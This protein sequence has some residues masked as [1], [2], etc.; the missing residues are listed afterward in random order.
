MEPRIFVSSTFYDLKHVR[1]RLGHFIEGYGFKPVLFENGDVGYRPGEELDQSCFFEMKNCDMAILIVGGR[2]GSPVS[3]EKQAEYETRDN[4][5][6]YTSVTCRE[7]KTAIQENIPVYVFVDTSVHEQ[8]NIYKHNMVAIEEKK[9]EIT[10]P[11]VDNLNVFRFIHSIH[12]IGHISIEAFSKTNDI[13]KFLKKQWAFLFQQYLQDRRNET[14]FMRMET[15]MQEMQSKLEKVNIMLDRIFNK[16]V[17]EGTP[18]FDDTIDEIK[19]EETSATFAGTF[20]FLMIDPTVDKIREY[21]QFF[22]DKLIQNNNAD[23]LEYPFSED[24][25]I[26]QKFYSV[27]DTRDAQVTDVKSR[28]AF[29]TEFIT[30]LIR[31]REKIVDKLISPR[32]LSQM[33]FIVSSSK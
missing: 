11:A 5:D 18:E 24:Y 7:F 33:R 17:T 22:V 32:N 12:S 30:N 3:A 25:T 27:F 28:L 26:Q 14:I 8:Y 19:L 31:Y 20:E 1:E 29:D 2:Y 21:L 23:F 10:F 16:V 4:F 9:C 13:E 15:P 6:K